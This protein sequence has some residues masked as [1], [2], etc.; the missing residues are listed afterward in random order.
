MLQVSA[1]VAK[2]ANEVD[3]YLESWSP[4]HPRLSR[5]HQVTLQVLK[6][7]STITLY[8]PLLTASKSSPDYAAAL[9]HCVSASRSIIKTLYEHISVEQSFEGAVLP[10]NW[11]SFTWAIW[12]SAFIIIY[13]GIEQ[14][15]AP[16]VAISSVPQRLSPEV[17]RNHAPD[18]LY[19]LADR[20]IEILKRVS[21]RGT[22]WPS[23][24]AAAVQQLSD[25]LRERSKW[26]MAQLPTHPPQTSQTAPIARRPSD[27]RAEGGEARNGGS[28]IQNVPNMTWNAGY[29]LAQTQDYGDALMPVPLNDVFLSDASDVDLFQGF[30]IPFWMGDDQ[31]ADWFHGN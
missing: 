30:D 7:E 26:T 12:M 13:A 9:Q 10:L 24:C 31:Y 11:P 20:S 17:L 18:L 21:A 1:K 3:G 5:L 28:E 15:M 14:E 27:V 2:W 16:A 4:S 29:D 6:D 23:A 25:R 19:R 22:P 8:R